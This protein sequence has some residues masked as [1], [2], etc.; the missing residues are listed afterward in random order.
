[1]KYNVISRGDAQKVIELRRAGA[2]LDI[3]IVVVER[4]YGSKL[5]EQMLDDAV[6]ALEIIRKRY[7]SELTLRDSKGGEFEVEASEALHQSLRIDPNVAADAEFWIFLA[8]TKFYEI[9][10][11]RHGRPNDPAKLS[12]FG[13]GNKWENLIQRL[14]YR[15]ELSYVSSLHDPY[16]LTR[17]GDQDFWRSH[18]LRQRYAACRPLTWELIRFQYPDEEPKTPKLHPSAPTGIRELAKRLKRIHATIALEILNGD[19]AA[20]LLSE[21][22]EELRLDGQKQPVAAD[23]ISTSPAPS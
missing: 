21:L 10:E 3:D 13:I 17:R 8:A 22:G 12:N 4:G 11:W 19:A 23:G 2:E 5:S 9:V 7:P 14:W 20:N 1:M 16:Q 18:I 6:E 15:A